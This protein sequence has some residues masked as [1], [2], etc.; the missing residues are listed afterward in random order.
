M[1]SEKAFDKFTGRWLTADK[2]ARELAGHYVADHGKVGFTRYR[3]LLRI[4]TGQSVAFQDAVI[5]TVQSR[6]WV[7][8]GA[9][10]RPYHAQELV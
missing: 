8:V 1:A 7:R 4:L 9:N 3:W 10:V 5:R 6:S 2:F